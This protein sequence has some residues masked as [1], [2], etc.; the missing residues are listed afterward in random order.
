VVD[1]GELREGIVRTLIQLGVLEKLD[2]NKL[3]DKKDDKPKR[4][5]SKS[6]GSKKASPPKRK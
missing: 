4:T 2:D 6:G 1:D 3:D 5:A